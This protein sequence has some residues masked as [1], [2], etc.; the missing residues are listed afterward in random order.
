MALKTVT[1]IIDDIEFQ[2]T[3]FPA[4]RALEVMVTL[5]KIAAGSNQS[6]QLATAMMAG[7]DQASMKKMVLDLLECTTALVPG[8]A[9]SP[10]KLIPLNKAEG[11]DRVFSGRLKMLFDVIHHAVEVNFGDFNEGSNDLAPQTLTQDQ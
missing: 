3:Q 2:T 1:K 11:I 8:T 7:M 10:T 5:Q 9:G 6:E 4:M